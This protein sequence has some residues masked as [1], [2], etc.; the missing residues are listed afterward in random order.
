MGPPRMGSLWSKRMQR[1]FLISLLITFLHPE[2]SFAASTHIGFGNYGETDFSALDKLRKACTP[3]DISIYRAQVNCLSFLPGLPDQSLVEGACRALVLLK[4]RDYAISVIKD[5]IETILPEYRNKNP[6]KCRDFSPHDPPPHKEIRDDAKTVTNTISAAL[7]YRLYSSDEEYVRRLKMNFPHLFNPKDRTSDLL[8]FVKEKLGHAFIDKIF[9]KSSGRNN[10]FAHELSMTAFKAKLD[11]DADFNTE[12]KKK[13]DDTK[14]DYAL[15]LIEQ[16]NDLC[17]LSLSQLHHSYPS[18]FD[19]FLIDLPDNERACFDLTL[20]N[21]QF[22]YDPLIYDSDCDGLVD[23]EDPS[24]K[25]PFDPKQKVSVTE[26]IY[27]S[28]FIGTV[29]DYTLE[30]HN[31]VIT[32]SQS[33]SFSF[34]DKLNESEKNDALASF[35]KCTDELVTDLQNAFRD[36]K[37]TRK[38]F[39]GTDLVVNISTEL[40]SNP[41]TNNFMI[42][43]CF[44]STCTVRYGSDLVDGVQVDLY[45]PKDMCKESLS[46]EMLKAAENRWSNQPDSKNLLISTSC[47][48]FKHEVLHKLGEQDEYLRSYYPF[49]LIGEDDSIMKNSATGRIYPRHIG[50]ILSPK[51]CHAQKG[52]RGH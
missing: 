26:S 2:L 51:A 8:D 18:M 31:N 52:N 9:N 28:P 50:H 30:K 3:D 22:Y 48:T 45:I 32:L 41:K 47:T 23:S 14:K 44:C 17:F 10:I 5:E 37:T 46:P 38:E 40:S 39:Q 29:V 49:N 11:T 6:I 42:H 19:Q 25:D 7:I 43:K 13:V 36:F 16:G 20:C 15:S 35:H 24:P 1:L 4:M 33:L 27:G 21:E 34:N 12:L